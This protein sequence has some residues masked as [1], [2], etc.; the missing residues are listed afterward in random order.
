MGALVFNSCTKD[1]TKPVIVINS[2]VANAE[3][4]VGEAF[5]LSATVTD[6][7]ELAKIS[8]PALTSLGDIT[9]FDSP[10][11]HSINYSV[12]ISEGTPVGNLTLV[13]NAEDKEGNVGTNSISVKVVE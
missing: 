3:Y 11:T 5:P 1:I 12:T 9:S 6:E 10:N 13:I 7:T 4:K 8:I 2:P